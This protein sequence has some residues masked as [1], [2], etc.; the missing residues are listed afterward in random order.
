MPSFT[1]HK[2]YMDVAD[3]AGNVWIGYHASADWHALHADFSHQLRRSPTAGIEERGEFGASPAPLWLDADTLAWRGPRHEALWRR[4]RTPSISET[5][6]SD[7]GGR[8]AW[9]CVLPRARA[10][11]S[12]GPDTFAGMGY[13]EHLELSIPPWRLPLHTLHWGRCHS[14]HHDLVWIRWDGAEPRALA[15]LDGVRVAG[16]MISETEVR[17]D[18]ARWSCDERCTLR[19]GAIGHTLL[20]RLGAWRAAIPA[21]ALALDEHKWF[22]RGRLTANGSDEDAVTIAERV[23]W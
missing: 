23:G 21:A 14:A 9:S 8:V 1:L 15:W 3:G 2:W 20:A 17:V 19:R 13:V 22:A 16:A 5:L 6:F 7:R 12:S 4:E 11:I 18:G 10:R